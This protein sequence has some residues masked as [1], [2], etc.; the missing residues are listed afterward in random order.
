[1]SEI[2]QN[3][4]LQKTPK[5][6]IQPISWF[7]LFFA[8]SFVLFIHLILPNIQGFL[9]SLLLLILTFLLLFPI[10][11]RYAKKGYNKIWSYDEDGFVFLLMGS[12]WLRICLSFFWS[13]TA[14]SSF[15]LVLA[16][17]STYL[18][19]AVFLFVPIYIYSFNFFGKKLRP[20]VSFYPL[21]IIHT[22]HLTSKIL[23]FSG[24]LVPIL[25]YLVFKLDLNRSFLSNSNLLN[26]ALALSSLFSLVSEK[27]QSLA[28][29]LNYQTLFL[30]I[31]FVNYLKY[32]GFFAALFLLYELSYLPTTELK[33]S[34]LHLKFFRQEKINL[35]SYQ[36][37]FIAFSVFGIVI[38]WFPLMANFEQ[39]LKDRPVSKY[40]KPIENYVENIT[41]IS[42][43]IINDQYV[44]VGTIA[45]ARELRKKIAEGYNLEEFN[46][47]YNAELEI[48]FG[49][50]K[51]NTEIFL[52]KYYS[53]PAEYLRLAKMFQGKLEGHIQT[54]L[55]E[56]LLTGDPFKRLNQI[57]LAEN[58]KIKAFNNEKLNALDA[59]QRLIAN[60]KV[61]LSDGQAA[62]VTE[63]FET[64]QLPMI[65]SEFSNM[66]KAFEQRL[67]LATGAG[68][69]T[70]GAL[71]A[72][73]SKKLIAKGTYKSL[74]SAVVKVL[75]KKVGASSAGAVIGG[76]IGS[77]VPF[78]GTTVGAAVGGAGAAL[79]AE[80]AGVEIDELINRDEVRS[81]IFAV[82]DAEKAKMM[83]DHNS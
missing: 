16:E 35:K 1:M 69:V 12:A 52:D 45:K 41:E 67:G 60:S 53:I 71:L 31:L 66:E 10:G 18:V 38:L 76:I 74:A 33:K 7:K 9:F 55:E 47:V 44:E 19:L 43:E 13:V 83:L 59:L 70:G 34:F 15:L 14:A 78:A 5:T 75:G 77:V 79:I 48:V 82:L 51:T 6:D 30:G 3:K 17:S 62:N 42:V 40:S 22:A 56:A 65:M 32:I 27:S 81:Q 36:L 46:K 61:E 37:K 11:L 23:C 39:T 73:I 80:W 49:K 29:D 54:Q 28:Q 2:S 64:D 4:Y 57:K 72:M 20:E 63:T 50:L 21:N 68:A 25:L 24:I 8:S 58:E 26:E